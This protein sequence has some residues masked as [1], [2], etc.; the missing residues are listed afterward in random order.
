MSSLMPIVSRRDEGVIKDIL[1]VNKV[2]LLLYRCG[3]FMSKSIL[4][5]IHNAKNTCQQFYKDY[6]KVDPEDQEEY[7]IPF[8]ICRSN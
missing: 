6:L 7:L 1:L 2:G 8:L 5:F 4:I 3:P